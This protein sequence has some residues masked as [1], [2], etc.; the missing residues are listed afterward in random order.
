MGIYVKTYV[1]MNIY[2]YREYI[3]MG[4]KEV[5]PASFFPF[6]S[7]NFN[8]FFFQEKYAQKQSHRKY[9]T[10]SINKKTSLDL[11]THKDVRTHKQGNS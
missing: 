5:Y 9:L 6:Q 11:D 10:L 7:H 8:R 4:G 1:Y 3:Y 2:T